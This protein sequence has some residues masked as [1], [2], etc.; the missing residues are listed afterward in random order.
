MKLALKK[1]VVPSLRRNGFKGAFPHLHKVYLNKVEYIS[2]Q[3][4]IQDRPAFVVCF[5]TISTENIDNQ[6]LATLKK[7]TA[8][9]FN[10]MRLGSVH[11]ED[12][13]IYYDDYKSL[14]MMSNLEQTKY[15]LQ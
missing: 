9:H 3:F 10:N 12:P 6:E 14:E 15:Y 11:D 5:A 2:F 4:A 7:K 1:Q 8:H 13:W